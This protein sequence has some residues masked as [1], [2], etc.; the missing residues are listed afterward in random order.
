MPP[1]FFVWCV[2]ENLLGVFHNAVFYRY[3]NFLLL[4]QRPDP[5]QTVLR[6][7]KETLELSAPGFVL[8]FFR[9]VSQCIQFV[10]LLV[11]L[12]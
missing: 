3:L 11:A 9:F 10:L 6:K 7:K 5:E 2:C 4:L 8:Q 1:D 12:I